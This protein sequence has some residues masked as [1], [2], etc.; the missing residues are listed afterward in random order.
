MVNVT[1]SQILWANYGLWSVASILTFMLVGRV[2]DSTGAR[3]GAVDGVISSNESV[4]SIV[5]L[6]AN[7]GNNDSKG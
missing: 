4:D 5:V 6:S 1:G 2:G 3:E 7:G